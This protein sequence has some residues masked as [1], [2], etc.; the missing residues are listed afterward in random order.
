MYKD[1]LP[2][3]SIVQLAGGER[4]VM[5]CGRI[6]VAQGSDEIYDYVACVYPEGIA[7]EDGLLFFNRDA[8][9]TVYFIGYQDEQE[10]AYRTEIL[11]EL[12]ELALLDG[13]IVPVEE[14]G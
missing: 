13:E 6:V 11:D 8:I 12:G 4:F 3:G 7:Q 5:I 2:I 1:L 14:K 10:L 9:E